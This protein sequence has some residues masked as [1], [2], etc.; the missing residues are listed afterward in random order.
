MMLAGI[1]LWACNA[2]E[3][4]APV[5]AD[6]SQQ[7]SDMTFKASMGKSL[8]KSTMSITTGEAKF[9]QDDCIKVFNTNNGSAKFAVSNISG[10]GSEA[11][12]AGEIESTKGYYAMLPYQQDATING[13]EISMEIPAEQTW[14]YQDLMVGYT[15]NADRSFQFRHVG[16]M[17]NFVTNQPYESITIESADGT[18]PI[19]G[20]IKVKI[21]ADGKPTVT[22]GTATKVTI[23]CDKTLDHANVLATLMPLNGVQLKFSFKRPNTT[24]FTQD[25]TESKTLLSGVMYTYDQVGKYKVICY[26]DAS[27]SEILFTRYASDLGSNRSRIT[28]PECPLPAAQGKVYGYGE[29]PYST[30]IQFKPNNTVAQVV[31]KDIVVYPIESASVKLT[32]YCNGN[33]KAP[34]VKEIFPNVNFP[35]PEITAETE[36]GY[37]YGYSETQDGS[38]KYES[39]SNIKTK[40]DVTLYLV[41]QKLNVFNIYFDG[42]DKEPKSYYVLPKNMASFTL[43]EL[44]KKD[45]YFAIYSI[46]ATNNDFT[47]YPGKVLYLSDVTYYDYYAVYLKY[48]PIS[49]NEDY[50]FNGATLGDQAFKND[51]T[52]MTTLPQVPEGTCMVFKFTNHCQEASSIDTRFNSGIRL[53]GDKNTS[54]LAGKD[55]EIFNGKYGEKSGSLPNESYFMANINNTEVTVKVFNHGGVADVEY[56][57]KGSIDNNSY[58]VKYSNICTW[59]NLYVAFYAYKS[60]IELQ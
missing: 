59:D 11:I 9:S 53:C 42:P 55:I 46:S 49:S 25:A 50:K 47:Y 18:T 23:Q 58:N 37:G 44:V 17:I 34:V 13:Q 16:T 5:G 52:Y 24:P 7:A 31:K 36:E 2:D 19:A 8:S 15:D 4:D 57:W 29:D 27:N 40:Q 41:K 10:D 33:D 35:L 32:V 39:G 14:E 60:Y 6:N 45:G 3:L 21:G 51:K 22:G 26:K 1:G 20:N 12:F 48:V 43:P 38:I 54:S 28:L 30:T 56:S